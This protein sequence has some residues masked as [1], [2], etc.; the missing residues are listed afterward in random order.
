MLEIATSELLMIEDFDIDEEE[1]IFEEL[2][3]NACIFA[4]LRFSL[5]DNVPKS[6]Q[7]YDEVLPNMDDMRFWALLRCTRQQFNILLKLIENHPV[8]HGVNSC[9]QFTVQFQLALVLY[10]LGFNGDGGTLTKIAA[11]FGIGDGET[12]RMLEKIF[13]SII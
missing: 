11:L 4:G 3:D 1:K 6:Y 12:S 5:R 2:E 13:R 10:R 7:W 8:F 9:K